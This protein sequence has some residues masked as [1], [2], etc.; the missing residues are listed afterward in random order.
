MMLIKQPGKAQ[1]LGEFGGIVVFI[2]DHQSNSAS[3]WGYITEKPATL[4]IKYTIMN[5]HL[6]LLQ[7]EGL[8]GSIYA[9]PSM[10]KENK[11]V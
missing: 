7:R 10:W 11:T 8:S 5:Q 3:A 6:Q 1:V 2:P 9:Q 4:P